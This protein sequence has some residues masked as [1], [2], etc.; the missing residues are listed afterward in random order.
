MKTKYNKWLGDDDYDAHLVKYP[1]ADHAYLRQPQKSV[2]ENIPA[3]MLLTIRGGPGFFLGLPGEPGGENYIGIPQGTEGNIVVVG[4]NGSGKSA[5]IA[6]PILRT[7][8]GAICATD[9]KGELSDSYAE[10]Y[11]CGLVNRPLSFSTP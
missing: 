2:L 5:G 9:I 6:K 11:H 8:R 7:W 1:P 3:A 10:L 4:G